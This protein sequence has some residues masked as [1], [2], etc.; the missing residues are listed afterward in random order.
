VLQVDA[1]GC[2]PGLLRPPDQASRSQGMGAREKYS[3]NPFP[4]T[5]TFTTFGSPVSRASVMRFAIVP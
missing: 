4:S 5:T 1:G 2:E 3:A